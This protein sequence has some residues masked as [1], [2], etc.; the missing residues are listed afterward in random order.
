MEQVN[1]LRFRIGTRGSK[2]A[3]QQALQVQEAL[4]AQFPQAEVELQVIHTVGDRILDRGLSQIG[5]KGLFTSEL[6][7]ALLRDEI[8]LAVHS[9]KDL[10][11]D[12]AESFTLAAV[13]EREFPADVFISTRYDTLEA[14]P[15]GAVVGTS[16]L[17]R[18]AQ[19]K[20]WRPDLQI[21]N[22]RGNV[23]TRLRKLTEQSLDGILLAW[24]GMERL[25]L[26]KQITQILPLE[27]ML[28]AVGQG[29]IGVQMRKEH[30]L[31]GA[32]Q[33]LNHE[34]TSRCVRAER[35]FLQRL[36]GGCQVPLAAWARCEEGKLHI[37]GRVIQLEG[38]KLFAAECVGE[39][40]TP[41]IL[42]L[43][44]ADALLEQ[45]A[46]VVFEEIRARQEASHG[47]ED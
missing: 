11:G 43:K 45:G 37:T 20:Y 35:A 2:L 36:E 28:P 10:P 3:L 33:Q 24:A 26:E 29:A 15:L 7:Q 1:P 4:R 30:P 25:G 32:V 47:K 40:E 27:R 9:M 31:L 5:D 39:M 38:K 12:M 22:V 42:G 23:E 41:E 14:L 18:A 44:V 46:Q 21:V 8:D 34:E 17:R 6:E 13:L 16:S 19:L